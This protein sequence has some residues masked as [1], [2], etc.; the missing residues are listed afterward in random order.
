M[1]METETYMNEWMKSEGATLA[2]TYILPEIPQKQR[3]YE[4]IPLEYRVFKYNSVAGVVVFGR[5]SGD[6]W[7]CN[8]KT[9]ALIKHLLDRLGEHP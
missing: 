1:N 9:R 7:I 3:C 5:F 4:D 6:R 2:Y 8:P